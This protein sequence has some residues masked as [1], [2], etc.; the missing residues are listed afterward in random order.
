MKILIN[1][2]ILL[3]FSFS[4]KLVNVS[5]NK[6]DTVLFTFRKTMCKGKCPVYYMEIFKSGKITFEGTKNVEKIGNY[7]KTIN[8]KKID[9]L[10]IEFNNAKFCDFENEY[11]SKKRDLP[12]TYISFVCNDT[13]KTVRDYD[14]AP[15]ELKNLEKTLENIVNSSDWV[16]NE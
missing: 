12:T 3:T 8:S 7:T 16:K 5:D 4:C 2:L 15:K 10:I 11:T 1:L 9:S 13:V 14:G 6:T